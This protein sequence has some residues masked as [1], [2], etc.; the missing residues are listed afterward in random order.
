MPTRTIPSEAVQK[1]IIT[2]TRTSG[3]TCW[4]TGVWIFY[5]LWLWLVGLTLNLAWAWIFMACLIWV[6]H[7][8]KIYW[9]NIYFKIKYFDQSDWNCEEL[10][11]EWPGLIE[12][13]RYHLWV[14]LVFE[15][16]IRKPDLW[17]AQK[18]VVFCPILFWFFYVFLF[19]SFFIFTLS[20]LFTMFMHDLLQFGELNSPFPCALPYF[21]Y[22]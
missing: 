21:S 17:F 5:K 1:L 2:F 9:I 12:I 22:S 20:C 3:G 7:T 6:Q 8:F 16:S 18:Y 10:S 11:D 13:G 19:C 14:L 4:I 15:I